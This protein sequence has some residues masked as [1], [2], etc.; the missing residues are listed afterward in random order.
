M[1]ARNAREIGIAYGGVIAVWLVFDRLA[2]Y[3][4]SVRGEA[5]LLVCAVVCG[6][7]LSIER[8][9]HR[10]GPVAALKAL[11]CGAPRARAMFMALAVATAIVAALP[12]AASLTK[13]PLA[14]RSDWLG[15]VPGLFAQAGLAEELLFRGYLFGQLRESRPF[16]RA[17][18]LALPPF[19]LVH[20]VLFA[21]MS[22][23]VA[24]AA[25]LLSLV[26]SFPLARLY[27]L[28]G[29]TVWAPAVVHAVIQG[30]IKIVDIPEDRMVVVATIWM[31][32]SMLMPWLAFAARAPSSACSAM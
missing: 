27:D 17:A 5:G 6:A 32:A 15:S 23:P 16:W 12:L 22:F 2:A 20:L 11:G 18:L 7:L 3:T 4:K 24:A 21:T 19:L 29:A 8:V 9:V 25:T 30:G 1:A 26:V 14:L 13:T 31:A 10:R 28:G